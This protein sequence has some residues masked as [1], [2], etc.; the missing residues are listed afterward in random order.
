GCRAREGLYKVQSC[1]LASQQAAGG[2]AQGEEQAVGGNA[3]TIFHGP[4]NAYARVNL[5]KYLFHP[6]LSA[7]YAVFTSNN[8][9]LSLVF[10]RDQLSGNVASAYI[11]RQGS[12]DA[13]SDVVWQA[14]NL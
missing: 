2:A 10:H 3:I 1:S 9:G 5:P 11:F 6:G 13:L 7:E 12:G 4:V 8:P 14:G